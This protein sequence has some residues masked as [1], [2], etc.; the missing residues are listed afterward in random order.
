MRR[1]ERFEFQN[2]RGSMELVEDRVHAR[3]DERPQLVRRFDA[4]LL[5]VIEQ[6]Q[7][8]IEGVLV[9]G[10][11]NLFL[12]LEVVVEISLLHVQRGGDVFAGGAVIS[13]PPEGLGGAL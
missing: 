6:R 12:V 2:Q 7:Q 9:A 10:K 4:A 5:D 1:G 11:E 13:A 8:T 3:D